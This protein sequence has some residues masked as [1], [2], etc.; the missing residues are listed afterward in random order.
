MMIR[1]TTEFMSNK[2]QIKQRRDSCSSI[3]SSCCNSHS[4][5]DNDY[6]DSGDENRNHDMKSTGNN[7]SDYEIQE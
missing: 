7:D 2:L 5:N 3:H 6:H 1:T 4:D